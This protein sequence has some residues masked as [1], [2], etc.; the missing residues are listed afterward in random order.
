MLRAW[1][2]ESPKKVWNIFKS[3]AAVAPSH[4]MDKN[5]FDFVNL[6]PTG[7][8]DENGDK[9]FDAEDYSQYSPLEEEQ[10]NISHQVLLGQEDEASLAHQETENQ[11]STSLAT[12]KQ[13]QENKYQ[14]VI[15]IQKL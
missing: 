12:D 4:L 7:I 15:T 6:R 5:L 13:H 10:S 11:M 2:K 14:K 9:A 8:A 1:E 3:L